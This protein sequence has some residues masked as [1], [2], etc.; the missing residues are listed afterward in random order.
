MISLVKGENRGFPRAS[1]NGRFLV[2]L[3]LVLV[4]FCLSAWFLLYA[5]PDIHLW[6]R[7][8]VFDPEQ[9]FTKD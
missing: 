5:E 3:L 7:A 1:E 2:S 6:S 4:A 8:C 9:A